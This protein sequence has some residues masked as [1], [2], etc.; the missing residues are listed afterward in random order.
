MV[1]A[2]E[3]KL[4]AAVTIGLY[5]FSFVLILTTSYACAN[6]TIAFLRA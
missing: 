2:H 5:L 6:A 4:L 1:P 3:V